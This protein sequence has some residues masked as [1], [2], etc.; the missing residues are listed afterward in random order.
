[1]C[2]ENARFRKILN[3]WSFYLALRAP[4]TKG[5]HTWMASVADLCQ[6]CISPA[7]RYRLLNQKLIPLDVDM[8]RTGRRCHHRLPTPG[9]QARL[10]FQAPLCLTWATNATLNKKCKSTDNFEAKE[11]EVESADGREIRST[12]EAMAVDLTSCRRLGRRST[13]RGLNQSVYSQLLTLF[14]SLIL[15][16][17]EATSHFI[18][19]NLSRTATPIAREHPGD[20]SERHPQGSRRPPR[21]QKHHPWHR[22]WRRLLRLPLQC[23]GRGQR[24]VFWICH[25]FNGNEKKE[26]ASL[27]GARTLLGAPGHTT[28]NKKLLVTQGIATRSLLGWRPLKSLDFLSGPAKP[29]D[30]T[31]QVQQVFWGHED[32]T[33]IQLIRSATKQKTQGELDGQ[34][35]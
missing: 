24:Q 9:S 3:C 23:C 11:V 4:S 10:C 29:A 27:L 30:I 25:R 33:M 13:R 22:P 28:R 16:L 15:H 31:D 12:S 1:M 5:F 19:V 21:H 20:R 14:L 34:L 35:N 26:R 2:R 18:S 32:C 17:F 6:H 7:K 8:G